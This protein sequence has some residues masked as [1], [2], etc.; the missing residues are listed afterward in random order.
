MRLSLQIM[1]FALV[2]LLIHTNLA[3]SQTT[4]PTPTPTCV[5]K[6]ID[7]EISIAS[8]IDQSKAVSLAENSDEFKSATQG[9]RVSSSPIVGEEW[10]LNST[11][12]SVTLKDVNVAF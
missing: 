2:F 12:C 9:Y 7:E 11:D 6:M 5:H 1:F 4:N 3:F 10:T 8:S